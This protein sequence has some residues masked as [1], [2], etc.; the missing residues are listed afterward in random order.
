MS[1]KSFSRR[2]KGPMRFRPTGGIGSPKA[3]Q[4]AQARAEATGTDIPE[5]VFDSGKHHQEIEQAENIAAGLPPD[6]KVTPV[7]KKEYKRDFR[8]PRLETPAEVHEEEDDTD[9]FEPVQ[10]A[11]S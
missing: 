7:E 2:R 10:V 1:D 9:I 4:A 11:D 5:E 6:E 3:G 8:E